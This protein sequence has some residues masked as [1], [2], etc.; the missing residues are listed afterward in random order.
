MKR[1]LLL[2][3]IILGVFIARASDSLFRYILIPNQAKLKT[4]GSL[5]LQLLKY[6]DVANKYALNIANP[7]MVS[8][9]LINGTIGVTSSGSAFGRLEGIPNNSTIKYYAPAEKPKDNTI[10]V[11]CEFSEKGQK[12]I[13]LA[14]IEI[15]NFSS[16]FC[17]DPMNVDIGVPG[18][19]KSECFYIDRKDISATRQN[20]S[21]TLEKA[22]HYS[23]LTPEQKL[24]IEQLKG[25]QKMLNKSA[26][27]LEWVKTSSNGTAVYNSSCQTFFISIGETKFEF[28]SAMSL[29]IPGNKPGIYFTAYDKCMI[30]CGGG[31]PVCPLAVGPGSQGYISQYCKRN[32]TGEC[33][34]IVIP[35]IIHIESVGKEGELVTGYFTGKTGKV[36]CDEIP[37]IHSI[38][39]YFSVVRQPD[40]NA[41][42]NTN[43]Y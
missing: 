28:P 39:G 17:I 1:I 11:S 7:V 33:E 4:G 20:M 13:L 9:W 5:T 32:E 37:E 34:P 2:S 41:P 31:K 26:D 14:Y 19:K 42:C 24:Q 35:C 6:D 15:D 43:K 23:T 25:Q 16:A 29:I 40:I 21:N 12:N 27:N 8:S 3:A 10:R 18:M 30:T 22:S 36:L 38:Y